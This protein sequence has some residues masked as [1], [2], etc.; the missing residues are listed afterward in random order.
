MPNIYIN[1]WPQ[2]SPHDQARRENTLLA[3]KLMLNAAMTAPNAGGITQVEANIVYGYEEQ[4]A[5]ARKMEE[6]ANNIKDNVHLER[7]FK[8]EAV[9]VREADVV[10]FLGDFRAAETPMDAGCGSC[11]G[12]EDC[13]FVYERRKTSYGLI[14][15]THR[16]TDT[17]VDGPLCGVRVNDF[18]YAI[19]S[20]LWMAN[21]LCVDARVF[22]S[23]GAA[24]RRLGYCPNSPIAVGIL[25][26]SLSKNPFVDINTD[27]HLVN[28]NKL[29]D[30]LRKVY[31]LV[32][33]AGGDYRVNDPG[34]E[35]E[36]ERR[37]KKKKED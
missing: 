18:G 7:I 16:R 27:Y 10:L 23:V 33:Q 22:M 30:S 34:A 17:L 31:T 15:W 26:A 21:R 24:G 37:K 25:I 2:Y 6:L 32:R 11:G 9:M 13:S 1:D 29:I 5:I 36:K 4:E 20:A 3:V 19:G 14:D 28:Q 35:L 12:V 8:Y